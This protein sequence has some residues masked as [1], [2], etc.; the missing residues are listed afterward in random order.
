[1][2]SWLPARITMYKPTLL[3]TTEEHGCS[4][5]TFYKRVQDHEQTLMIIKTFNNDVFGAYCSV[6]WYERNLKDDNGKKQRY[7]GTG[8]TFLFSLVPEKKKYPWVGIQSD[9]N[10]DH[11]RELFMAAD[12]EMITIGGG[13][14]FFFHF[15]L[16]FSRRV[17]K[18]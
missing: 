10:C 16:H 2:W 3:Y 5:K 13:Y 18:W 17:P 6:S 15:L 7:F 9:K 1:M 8:E 12:N 11:S 4:L 14:V